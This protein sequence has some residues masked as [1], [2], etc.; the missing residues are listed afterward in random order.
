MRRHAA[1]GLGAVAQPS[2]TGS[3][4]T[5]LTPPTSALGL[6]S[7]LQGCGRRAQRWRTSSARS[8]RRA[9]QQPEQKQTNN[10]TACA[11][12]ECALPTAS[13]GQRWATATGRQEPEIRKM[14]EKFARNAAVPPDSDVR[15]RAIP[16]FAP[17]W[18]QAQMGTA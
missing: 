3:T 18:E 4:A 2:C 5:G 15:A 16:R 10:R 8:C 14:T 1:R 12:R 13:D 6:R 7:R 11:S 17:K 9:N